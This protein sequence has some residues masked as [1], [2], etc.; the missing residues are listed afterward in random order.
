MIGAQV[1]SAGGIAAAHRRAKSMGAEA[2][3]CFVQ[4]PRIWKPVTH[5]REALESV[6]S[7]SGPDRL[8]LFVHAAYLVN[9][10]SPDP[11]VAKRS[12]ASLIH[13]TE[14]AGS[15]G[16]SGVVLHPGSHKGSGAGAGLRA[17]AEGVLNV[18]D[19]LGSGCTLLLE[20]TAGGG[21]TIGHSTDQLCELIELC[22][23]DPRIGICLD[24]QHLWASG[25]D[26]STLEGT[27]AF[28]GL[29]RA[30][31]G[32]LRLGLVHLNDSK[33][34]LGARSDRHENLGQGSIGLDALAT[35]MGHP[36]VAAVPAV[37]EV[38]GPDRAG[39]GRA[40]LELARSI[41]ERGRRMWAGG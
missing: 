11:A 8:P 19:A 30:R 20:N 13:Q 4:S 2:W 29:L 32:G 38:P 41:V 27:E 33:V 40:D 18:L 1:S 28:L 10:A 9:L 36:D 5:E 21:D 14:V 17:I 37:L 26:Y 24:T 12:L 3:Q 22:G 6:A 34:A 39:P 25:V 35:F 16:A 7:A 31:L 23:D 15:A